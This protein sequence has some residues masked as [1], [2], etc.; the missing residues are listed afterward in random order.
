MLEAAHY[1]QLT[2]VHRLIPWNRDSN[3]EAPH[4][5]HTNVLTPAECDNYLMWCTGYGHCVMLRSG[6]N[7]CS[8]TELEFKTMQLLVWW[9]WK[10]IMEVHLGV[11]VSKKTQ[12]KES[13]LFIVDLS[14][15]D[16]SRYADSLGLD[17]WHPSHLQQWLLC[18]TSAYCCFSLTF[19][20]SLLLIVL[21]MCFVRNTSNKVSC[22]PNESLTDELELQLMM[23]V[24][25]CRPL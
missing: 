16:E 18:F 6:R 11:N 22:S 5:L 4:W 17:A 15:L 25:F 9:S 21:C 2:E 14:D 19:S 1:L 13:Q 7:S 23:V 8:C 3:L 24:V 12:H 10:A 20:L